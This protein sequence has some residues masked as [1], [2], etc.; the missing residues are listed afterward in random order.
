M[1]SFCFQSNTPAG[2]PIVCDESKERRS[3]EWVVVEMFSAAAAAAVSSLSSSCSSLAV[4][5]APLTT[6]VAVVDA[7]FPVSL[8]YARTV[9][10]PR[11]LAAGA[12]KYR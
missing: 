11:R 1:K 3:T 10:C 8:K 5:G 4:A 9:N 7:S 2:F 6:M 12:K